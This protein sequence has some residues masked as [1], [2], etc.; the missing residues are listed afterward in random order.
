MEDDS[1]PLPLKHDVNFDV[2]PD[3]YEIS[4]SERISEHHADL[5]VE[6]GDWLEDEKGALNLGQIDSKAL[7]A[8]GLLTSKIRLGPDSAV[9]ASA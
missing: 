2:R 8:D 3:G 7:L 5:V 4:F 6:C 1:P 9:S